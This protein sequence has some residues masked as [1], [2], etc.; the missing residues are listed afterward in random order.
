MTN[1]MP[2]EQVTDLVTARMDGPLAAQDDAHGDEET[3][4][5]AWLVAESVRYLNVATSA[6][7]AIGLTA[8]FTAY[9]VVGGLAVS[10]SRLGQLAGQLA[11]WLDRELA[12]GRLD[13]SGGEPAATAGRARRHLELAAGAAVLVERAMSEARDDM[14]GLS[15]P[16]TD[17]PSGSRVDDQGS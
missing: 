6:R 2:L 13:D 9:A 7:S 10:M 14:A 3:A 12:A 4:A 11:S 5:A 16:L 8:P 15:R 1:L 17:T